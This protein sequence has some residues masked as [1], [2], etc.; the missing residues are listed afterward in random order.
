MPPL[1][2]KLNA[3][4]DT[5]ARAVPQGYGGLPPRG[6][7]QGLPQSTHVDGYKRSDVDKV[8]L[9]RRNAFTR[10]HDSVG[11][12]SELFWRSTPE[13]GAARDSHC[14]LRRGCPCW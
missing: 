13:E 4:G 3:P 6:Q 14:V 7:A 9:E 10:D 5:L 1:R 11:K 8:E 2:L 12:R